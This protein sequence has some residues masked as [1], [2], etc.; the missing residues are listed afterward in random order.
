L[1][2]HLRKLDAC[3]KKYQ[4]K[5]RR[6]HFECPPTPMPKRKV[7]RLRGEAPWF[8]NQFSKEI[9]AR[10][11]REV[12]ASAQA[13]SSSQDGQLPGSASDASLWN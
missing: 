1:D 11:K 4:T 7:R 8:M 12:V 5:L 2:G 10:E 3:L 13:N 6:N 9:R